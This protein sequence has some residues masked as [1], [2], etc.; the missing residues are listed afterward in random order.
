[1]ELRR[2]VGSSAALGNLVQKVDESPAG[3]LG[4]FV[5]LFRGAVDIA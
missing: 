3:V 1:M 5:V 4:V 2:A